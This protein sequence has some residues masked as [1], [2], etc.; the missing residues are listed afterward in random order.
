MTKQVRVALIGCGGMSR[1]H[2]HAIQKMPDVAITAA[3]DIAAEAREH[4]ASTY[5]ATPYESTE[6]MLAAS[7]ADAAV[8]VTRNPQHAELTVPCLEAG[9]PVLCEKP[10]ATTW[11]DCVRMVAAQGDPYP[12]LQIGFELRTCPAF[13]TINEI[14]ASGEIGEVRHVHFLQTPGAKDVGSWHVKKDLSG[15][16]F[17]EKLCHQIDT[18]RMLLGCDVEEVVAIAAKNT[19]EHY[20]IPDNV[21]ATFRF[22]EGK[23]A[24][25]S[26]IAGRAAVVENHSAEEYMDKMHWLEYIIIGTRGSISLPLWK[27]EIVVTKRDGDHLVLDRRIGL[28]GKGPEAPYH[29]VTAELKMFFDAVRERRR[30]PFTADDSIRTMQAVFASE[31]SLDEGGRPVAV[32]EIDT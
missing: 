14:I 20:E 24:H 30:S 26:F 11:A 2:G 21:Y 4:A 5:D 6:A 9:L 17:F 32:T 1:S 3:V 12:F 31:K 28:P 19:F 16:L 29:D 25:V 27:Q 23:V 15:G 18:F 8:V 22:P 10:M 7:A 13:A